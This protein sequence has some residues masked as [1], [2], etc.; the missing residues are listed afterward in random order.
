MSKKIIN[1]AAELYKELRNKGLELRNGNGRD[2][3]LQ[4]Q[5]AKRLNLPF[6]Q[7]QKSLDNSSISAE[8]FLKNFLLVAKPFSEMYQEIWN[9]LSQN[10]APKSKETL[11]IRFGFSGEKISLEAFRRHV[12]SLRKLYSDIVNWPEDAMHKLFNLSEILADENFLHGKWNE[13]KSYRVGAEYKLPNI[14]Q[15]P[16]PIDNFISNIKDLFQ[17]IINDA[18]AGKIRR[19]EFKTRL[20]NSQDVNNETA[21]FEITE[22]KAYPLTDL[23][24]KWYIIFSFL[25][26]ISQQKKDEAYEYFHNN[27]QP[28]LI[29]TNEQKEELVRK[30]L[31]ILDLPFW[32]NRWHTYEI[33]CSVLVLKSLSQFNPI[34]RVT[35]TRCVLESS[36]GAI[37]ADLKANSF[38]NACLAIQVQ[39]PFVLENRMGIMPDLRICFSEDTNNINQTAAVVEYKQSKSLTEKYINEIAKSYT[40]GAPR[41]GGTIIMNY[42]KVHISPQINSKSYFLQEV[43]PQ[44]LE[45]LQEFKKALLIILH[46]VNFKPTAYKVILLD[47]SGSMED[48]Y[49]NI[50]FKKAIENINSVP[51]VKIYRFS[52]GIVKDE[53]IQNYNAMGTSGGTELG[54]ALDELIAIVNPI[55]KLLIVSDGGHDHPDF[56][57]LNIENPVRECLPVNLYKEVPWFSE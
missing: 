33:W 56:F 57:K 14:E 39:T 32:K 15:G 44:N 30:A 6:E 45:I 38:P 12:Q 51:H 43:Q 24:P 36:S 34:L 18:H 19:D 49:R 46:R 52:D 10:L 55:Q 37:I 13:Y 29:T 53:E 8:M 20:V 11:S 26:E 27:I 23:L 54:K 25:S 17:N 5:L 1:T 9:Y 35:D 2:D 50:D 31:D 48:A 41:S 28:L 47:V 7:F 16:N 4:Q 40:E 3:D 22:E 21:E 42:D